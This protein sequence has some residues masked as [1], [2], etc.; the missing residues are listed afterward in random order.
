MGLQDL[1]TETGRRIQEL[2]GNRTQAEFAALLGVDRKSVTGWETGK[3]LPDGAS[4]L[5]MRRDLG[6]DVN[7]LL[8]GKADAE[9]ALSAEERTLLDYFRAAP[10]AVRRAA[11][12][13]LLGASAQ[14]VVQHGQGI[15]QV[16]NEAG[17]VQIGYVGGNARV[18][19]RTKSRD[20]E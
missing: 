8:G 19:R 2:R 6:A 4:L 3:R 10:P 16:S 14:G 17:A 20:E 15:Q 5:V 12:G 1:Y 11:M 9:P 7:Y 18:G 13:A